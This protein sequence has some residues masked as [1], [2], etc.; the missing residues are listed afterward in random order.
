MTTSRSGAPDPAE[1]GAADARKPAKAKRA[2][3]RRACD[4][5]RLARAKCDLTRPCRN[6]KQ[7]GREC[8]SKGLSEF[9]GIASAT[10]YPSVHQ[11]DIRH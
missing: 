8:V 3:V 9:K 4:A 6:C 11:I 1:T 5:C 7:A 2:Q 10:R